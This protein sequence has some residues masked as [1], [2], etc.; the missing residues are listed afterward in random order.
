MPLRLEDSPMTGNDYPLD[1]PHF[2]A[3]TG[4]ILEARRDDVE[5]TETFLRE[6]E[7]MGRRACQTCPFPDVAIIG[8]RWTCPTCGVEFIVTDRWK[9]IGAMWEPSWAVDQDRTPRAKD[10]P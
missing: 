4:R 6:F 1:D 3:I 7:A 8:Q 2:R 5:R 10:Q 9:H